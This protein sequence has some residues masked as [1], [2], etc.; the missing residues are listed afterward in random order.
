MRRFSIR[1]GDLCIQS[2]PKFLQS[3]M[4]GMQASLDRILSAVVPGAPHPAQMAPPPPGYPPPGMEP[5]RDP[6]A[7]HQQ[8]RQ[9]FDVPPVPGDRPRFPPLPGFAPPVSL[10]RVYSVIVF[11]KRIWLLAPQIC[12]LW[13][14][15]EYCSFFRGRVGGHSPAVDSQRPDRGSSGSGQRCR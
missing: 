14:S 6:S 10:L 13:N 11:L 5:P 2:F 4:I 1:R 7:A 12:N 3:Q 15:A 8:P 9:P